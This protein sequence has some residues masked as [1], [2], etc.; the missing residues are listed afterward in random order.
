MLL[1]NVRNNFIN[2]ESEEHSDIANVVTKLVSDIIKETS[3]M[4]VSRTATADKTDWRDALDHLIVAQMKTNNTRKHVPVVSGPP[5]IGKTSYAAQIA[6]KHNLRLIE[7][8]VSE[9]F[10]EDAIGMP[11]PGDK[12]DSGEM[13]VKFSLPK[14]YEQI[15]RLIDQKDH[16]YI[17]ALHREYGANAEQHIKK[18]LNQRYKYLIFFDEINRVDER[19][20]NA[21]RRV[22]L[23]RNFGPAGDG[24]GKLL[25]LPKDA[26]VV[27]AMN[28]QGVGTSQLT[29]HFRDVM[30]V[31]PAR[32]SW[33]HLTDWLS[34]KKFKGVP[35]KI[36]D[37][38]LHFVDLFVNKFMSRDTSKTADER[39]FN[40]DLGNTPIYISP[41]EYNDLYS[42]IVRELWAA[43]KDLINDPDMTADQIKSEADQAVSE[44]FE[45]SLNM[46]FHKNSVEPQEFMQTLTQWIQS[47][48]ITSYEGLLSKRMQQSN[49]FSDEISSYMSGSKSLTKMLDDAALVNHMNTLDQGQLQ[50]EIT[51]GVV[52]NIHTDQDV[53]KFIIDADQ[54]KILL[55]DDNLVRDP[56]QK[57]TRM[58]NV[59]TCLLYA[60]HVHQF[61]NDR[62]E[63]VA[64]AC[65]YANSG[66]LKKLRERGQVDSS[67]QTEFTM[68]GIALRQALSDTIKSL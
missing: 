10:A 15:N 16:S 12:S 46:I 33:K 14:L 53:K 2:Y 40:L 6:L 3:G 39:K 30:D 44:A 25:E 68:K 64:K 57:V 56:S 21:L 62:L 27:A 36:T 35:D 52:S 63:H 24:S 51:D 61:S 65:T 48:P 29:Q 31:V 17:E 59:Y 7:I 5:G 20:F 37:A 11:I 55:K 19:T 22:M 8:D 50:T 38:A 9:I 4:D 23:E 43:V 32:P 41:R 45:D 60:L 66:I 49:K 47:L 13:S 58:T 18:Y 42:T 28:P 1:T 54:D 34:S 67:I 26:I